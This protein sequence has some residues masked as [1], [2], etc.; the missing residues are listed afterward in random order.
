MSRTVRG[1]LRGL[2]ILQALSSK[3]ISTAADIAIETGLPRPTVHRMLTTLVEAGYAVQIGGGKFYGLASKVV[4]LSCGYDEEAQVLERAEPYLKELTARILWPSYL[5]TVDDDAL[6]TRIICRSP[7][8]LGTPRLGTRLPFAHFSAGRAYL[9]SLDE[10]EFENVAKNAA[11][12]T[13]RK[14]HLGLSAEMLR[15]IVR[16]VRE[17]GFGFRE[18]GAV[19]RTCSFALPI[20]KNGRPVAFLTANFI[21]SIYTLPKAVDTYYEALADT[22][23]GIEKD[24]LQAPNHSHS[25]IQSLH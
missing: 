18:D 2:E 23:S 14:Q 11:Q 8:E 12:E 25:A 15:G 20:R 13:F 24:I 10:Q 1:Y 21:S 16:E 17:I 9:A 3:K 19:P 6:V 4:Q 7:R 22:V 5:H